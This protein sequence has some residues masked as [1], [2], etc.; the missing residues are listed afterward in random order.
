MKLVRICPECGNPDVSKHDDN[1]ECS[2]CG[3]TIFD[4]SEMPAKEIE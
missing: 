3:E 1:Y 4:I 2:S